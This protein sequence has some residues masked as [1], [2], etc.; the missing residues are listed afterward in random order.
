M[1]LHTS[2][3]RRP[4]TLVELAEVPGTGVRGTLALRDLA[5]GEEALS[6]PFSLIVRI[7]K[8]NMSYAVRCRA[9]QPGSPAEG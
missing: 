7:G 3:C 5:E 6:M 8:T 2:L 4:Q 1:Q 9:R